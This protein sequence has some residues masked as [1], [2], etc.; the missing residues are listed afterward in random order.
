MYKIYSRGLQVQCSE[1]IE[2]TLD[3][4][5]SFSEWE[6]L[7]VEVEG[8]FYSAYVFYSIYGEKYV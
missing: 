7:L 3:A 5:D 1:S 8:M 2:S 4:L 6:P